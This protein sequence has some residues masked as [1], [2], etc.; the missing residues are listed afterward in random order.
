MLLLTEPGPVLVTGGAGFIGSHLTRSLLDA[1]FDV[2]VLDDFSAASPGLLPSDCRLRVLRGSVLDPDATAMA[3]RGAMFVFHLAGIVGMNRV[4]AI[5]ELT[6]R[7]SLAGTANVLRCSHPVP[8]VL[9][10]SSAVY[11]LTTGS[12]GSAEGDASRE[13]AC[14]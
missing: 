7:T 4:T 10:S 12:F 11:G 6:Y 2:S 9:F 14:A 8:V 1:G 3:C 13:K 5:P